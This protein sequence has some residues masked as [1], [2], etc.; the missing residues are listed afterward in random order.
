V[1]G[2]AYR[3]GFCHEAGHT[4]PTCPQNSKNQTA[5]SLRLAQVG[6]AQAKASPS[7]AKAK[8]PSSVQRNAKKPGIWSAARQ[9]SKIWVLQSLA[10]GAK[11][12]E[13]GGTEGS[14]SLQ[15]ASQHGCEEVVEVLLEHGADAAAKDND[16]D[17]SLHVASRYG[18]TAVVQQLLHNFS[19]R[20]RKVS[21]QLSA[22]DN[23]GRTALHTAAHQGQEA[24]MKLLLDSGAEISPPDNA[25]MTP[26]HS[27]ALLGRKATVRLLLE[28]NADV[29]ARDNNGETPLQHAE[30]QG[31]KH[32]AQLLRRAEVAP[33]A[34]PY[35]ACAGLKP[36]DAQ[37]YA[38]E[39]GLVRETATD[40]SA[41]YQSDPYST[42][43]VDRI[44][45]T[46]ERL[47]IGV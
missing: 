11:I 39:F 1:G 15:T 25:G 13:R 5:D 46:L 42:G 7:S 2:K 8:I 40:R 10:D 9:G 22:K 20:Y 17:T 33:P 32:V 28:R 45:I 21:T 3:C 16:G 24:V 23:A 26:L 18:R 38:S 43:E 44:P 29:S 14:T 41:V 47:V 27:A 12:E 35:F 6:A 19:L 4:K 37:S 31:C 34:A 30:F 36:L